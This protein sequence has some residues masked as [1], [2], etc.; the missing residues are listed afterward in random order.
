MQYTKAVN[1]KMNNKIYKEK[2][3]V[4]PYNKLSFI[5]DRF[6]YMDNI[7][8]ERFSSLGSFVDRNIVEGHKELQQII[9]YILIF[10]KDIDKLYI[11]KRIDGEKRLLNK[12]SIAV[13][14][15]INDTD[16]GLNRIFNG[17]IRE[18][19]EEVELTNAE[20]FRSIGFIR[21]INSITN[22]HL[23]IVFAVTADDAKI[24]E[25]ESLKGQWMKIN[26]IANYYSKLEN[27]CKNIL[28]YLIS[29]KNILF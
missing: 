5:E 3:L 12:V 23:G 20:K 9:A 4:V 29:N 24:I 25:K 11:N 16:E 22:D 28:E 14:G 10:N 18:L 19:H 26:D 15:H 17:A 7:D 2:V 8:L 1:T 27:W 21:D 6:T 13:G